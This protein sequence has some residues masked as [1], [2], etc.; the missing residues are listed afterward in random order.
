LSNYLKFIYCDEIFLI[1]HKKPRLPSIR[2]LSYTETE[3]TKRNTHRILWVGLLLIHLK[4]HS[5][6]Y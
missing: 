6:C 2:E 5:L 3:T 1:R 4:N